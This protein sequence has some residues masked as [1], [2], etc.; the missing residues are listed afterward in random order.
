[1]VLSFKTA[2]LLQY[3]SVTVNYCCDLCW[4]IIN[5]LNSLMK[6]NYLLLIKGVCFHICYNLSLVVWVGIPYPLI[7]ILWNN[8]V[9]RLYFFVL[10]ICF[11]RIILYR[12]NSFKPNCL[13]GSGYSNNNGSTYWDIHIKD[14]SGVQD[15]FSL[16]SW[17][18]NIM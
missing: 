12:H 2:L 6:S 1:M 4:I 9:L 18:K 5:I 3:Y 17:P 8:L 16:F 14:L 7:Q 11:D 10:Y 15:P 13:S